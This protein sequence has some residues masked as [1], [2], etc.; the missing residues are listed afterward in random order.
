[1]RSTYSGSHTTYRIT[2]R[3]CY[4]MTYEFSSDSQLEYNVQD[5]VFVLFL[6]PSLKTST[7]Y[8]NITSLQH[9]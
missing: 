8:P 1:M 4:N 9:Y 6:P 7:I 5:S 3:N 2:D